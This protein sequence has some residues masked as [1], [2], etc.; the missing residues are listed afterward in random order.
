MRVTAAQ[1]GQDPGKYFGCKV[2][3]VTAENVTV[4]GV[5]WDAS[6]PKGAIYANLNVDGAA[7]TVGKLTAIH[8]EV[9]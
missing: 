6:A 1:I 3:F 5:L 4:E 2:Q 8:V 7:C 9:S